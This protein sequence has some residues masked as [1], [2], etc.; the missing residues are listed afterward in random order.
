MSKSKPG[1]ED[2][3]WIEHQYYRTYEIAQEVERIARYPDARELEDVTVDDGVLVFAP[4]WQRDSVVHKFA[5]RSAHEM[6][7]A[8]TDG[9]YVGLRKISEG[10]EITY[11]RYLPVDLALVTYGLA[12]LEDAFEVPPPD[13]KWEKVK[14]NINKWQESSVVADACYDYFIEDLQLSAVYEELLDRIADEV[15]HLVFMN[16]EVLAGLNGYLAG[17]IQDINVDWLENSD[18]K[19]RELF[20][21]TG[22]RLKRSSIPRW[23]KRAVFFRE[24][25]KCAYCGFDLS[26]LLDA[27]PGE[28]FDHMIPLAAGGLND[29]TNIQLLCQ[30]CNNK[31]SDKLIYPSQRYRRWY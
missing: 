10:P 8:D 15:F 9:P 25:G 21:R 31:K 30:S 20:Y 14:P 7:S 16:R 29:I 18:S 28:Q 3:Y 23:V 22:G 27:L 24:H 19:I 11:R 6:F 26:G 5:R 12:T 1:K 17:Y 13:G 2:R 4:S